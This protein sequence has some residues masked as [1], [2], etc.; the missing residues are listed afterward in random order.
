MT[1][2]LDTKL[3]ASL[4]ARLRELADAIE[5]GS[6]KVTYDDLAFETIEILPDPEGCRQFR[7]G[8]RRRL[9]IHWTELDIAAVGDAESSNWGER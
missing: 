2:E 3:A 7:S 8:P 9:R 5:A 4:A 6:A 1:D